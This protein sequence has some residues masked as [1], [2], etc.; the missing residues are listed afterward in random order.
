M[1]DRA[2]DLFLVV[3]ETLPSRSDAASV[4]LSLFIHT[5]TRSRAFLSPLQ[6]IN[7][8]W[9]RRGKR[10]RSRLEISLLTEWITDPPPPMRSTSRG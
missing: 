3:V 4:A 5:H 1:V 2:V 10:L 7:S 9:V 8:T 6:E